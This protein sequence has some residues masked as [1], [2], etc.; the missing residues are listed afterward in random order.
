MNETE[1]TSPS[2]ASPSSSRA[3]SINRWRAEVEAFS[4]RIN[5]EL[6]D[7]MSQ[8]GRIPAVAPRT[9]PT[10]IER[11]VP[12]LSK[13]APAVAGTRPAEVA[14]GP[15]TRGTEPVA[16]RD[17]E[18]RLRSLREQFAAKLRRF[19]SEGL[20][21]S[22][23][24]SCRQRGGT[25]TTSDSRVCSHHCIFVAGASTWS[26]PANVVREIT[27]RPPITPIPDSPSLLA[28]MC[29]LR[30][31]F[32][33]V[34]SLDAIAGESAD[35][36]T[37][38]DHL[39]VLTGP[40]G[41]W[42]LLIDRGVTLEPLEIA[43]ADDPSESDALPVVMG[44]ASFR[45]EVVQVLDIDGLLRTGTQSLARHWNRSESARREQRPQAPVSTGHH[46][47]TQS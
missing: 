41:S 23:L 46:S 20:R 16:D 34:F 12:A 33:P 19:E 26:V 2:A 3:A 27:P 4:E 6:R 39:L 28:G 9:V 30:N 18:S 47:G 17:G 1:P 38:R 32:L 42:G 5:A 8:A 25:M 10:P 45:E 40:E 35:D 24:R 13:P 31:E 37:D 36:T 43:V 21:R 15:V 44:T 7:L 29:H 22:R 11:P 14:T